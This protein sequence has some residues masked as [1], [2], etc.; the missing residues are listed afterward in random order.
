MSGGHFDYAYS[1]VDGFVEQ[2][3]SELLK[4]ELQ[5]EPDT[6][7]ELRYILAEAK[8][9]SKFMRGAEWLYS[10]DHS[11]ESFRKLCIIARH[12]NEPT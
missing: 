1:R 6:I 3:E 5:F 9:M 2:L 11:E 4:D 7:R 10:G 8:R 12:T